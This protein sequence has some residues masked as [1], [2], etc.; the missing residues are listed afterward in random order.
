MTDKYRY[1]HFLAPKFWLTWLGIAGLH[2][3]AWLPWR[4]KVATGK[5]LAHI[6]KR[7][8]KSRYQTLQTNIRLCFPDLNP[9]EQN[10]LIEDALFSNVFGFI[11][12]A[13]A[14]C[15]GLSGVRIEVQGQEH[16]D[17]AEQDGRGILY[18]TAHWSFL[19]L[20]AAI[21]GTH[22]SAGT[23]YR[24]HDNP[25]FNYF[26]T[27]SREKH[28]AYT[29]ARKDVKGMIRRL[30][31]GEGL[32]YMPDQDFGPK[33]S[34]FVPFFGVPTATIT[35]TSKLAEAGNAIVLPISGYRKGL[36]STYV[37]RIDPPLAIPSGDEEQDTILWTQWLEGVV[38]QHPDQYLW[39]HKRFKT[40]PPGEPSVYAKNARE[41]L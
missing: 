18:M 33:R 23:I 26:M 4:A 15:R 17:A 22:L 8:A 32:A 27:R 16:L 14:W 35:M 11:E 37:F 1:W 39:L 31:Q 34:I 29:V 20:G 3:L 12:T 2:L 25:L 5:G 30:R 6:I 10:Q 13:H 21:I 41:S 36:S 7:V 40:R 38:A 24:K 9:D 19:D 28:L